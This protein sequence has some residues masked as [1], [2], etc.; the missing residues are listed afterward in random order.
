MYERSEKLKDA[1]KLVLKKRHVNRDNRAIKDKLKNE[2]ELKLDE[3]V[4]SKAISIKKKEIKS[5]IVLDEISD[6]DT[7]LEEIKKIRKKLKKRSSILHL[8]FH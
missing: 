1:F 3:K 5:Q 8:N 7:P 4:L 2:K 6:D